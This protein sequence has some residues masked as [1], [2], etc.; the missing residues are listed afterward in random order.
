[1][2]KFAVMGAPISHSH[3]PTLHAAG[4]EYFGIEAE[5]MAVEKSELSR[6]DLADYAGLSL[7]M[8][9]KLDAFEL[10]DTHDDESLDTGVSNTL[11]ISA[12]R[13]MALNTDVYG[14]SKS[15]E[16]LEAE[17]VQIIGTGATAKSAALAVRDKKLFFSGRNPEKLAQIEGWAKSKGI[18]LLVSNKVDVVIDTTPGES[19]V[20]YVDYGRVLDVAYASDRNSHNPKLISGLEMLLH[21]A[22][23][24]NI[25]FSAAQVKK[26]PDF[27]ELTSV[28]RRALESRVGEW[29]NA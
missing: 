19:Q 21:Q 16:S 1:M 14:V 18:E 4:F 29:L 22:V 5:Y 23:A 3:S 10:A 25:V 17:S 13:V 20:E 7:T 15:I 27:D 8:P 6:E 9:L 11:L 12:N 2:N 26:E 28:M 24:Q